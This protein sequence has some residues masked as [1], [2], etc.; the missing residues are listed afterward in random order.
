MSYYYQ[1][2]NVSVNTLFNHDFPNLTYIFNIHNV[3]R[4]IQCF[5]FVLFVIISVFLTNNNN[6]ILISLLVFILF[7]LFILNYN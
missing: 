7:Y 5:Y 6:T 2:A 3:N 4:I 1:I